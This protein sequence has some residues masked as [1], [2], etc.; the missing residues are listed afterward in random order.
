MKSI[1]GYLIL[2][3]LIPLLPL[4]LAG[5]LWLPLDKTIPWRKVP[6]LWSGLYVLCIAFA[7]WYFELGVVGISLVLLLGI[8]LTILGIIE[9]RK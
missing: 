5:A 2:I 9:R 6:L 8:A 7:L 4:L 1:V 3:P